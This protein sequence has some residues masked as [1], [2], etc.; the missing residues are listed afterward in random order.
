MSF[1]ACFVAAIM[2]LVAADGLNEARFR[3]QMADRLSAALYGAGALSTA[4]VVALILSTLA[5]R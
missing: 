2:T 4:V 1:V 5:V 3:W